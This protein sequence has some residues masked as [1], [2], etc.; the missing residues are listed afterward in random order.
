MLVAAGRPETPDGERLD[1]TMADAESAL[2]IVGRWQ[3]YASRSP[4]ESGRAISNGSS[5]GASASCRRMGY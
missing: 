5:S 4:S 1:V 2:T 3:A